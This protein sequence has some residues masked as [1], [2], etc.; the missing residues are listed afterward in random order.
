M[1]TINE[2]KAKQE[3][4]TTRRRGAKMATQAKEDEN[5]QWEFVIPRCGIEKSRC[6]F[7]IPPRILETWPCGFPQNPRLI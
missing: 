2:N 5:S 6:G 3:L 7:G 1:L 4:L